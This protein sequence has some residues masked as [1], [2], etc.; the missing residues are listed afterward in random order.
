MCPAG[1]TTVSAVSV[2]SS[3]RDGP[4]S[5]TITGMGPLSGGAQ[6]PIQ[7]YADAVA[8]L[9]DPDPSRRVAALHSLSHLGD[10][11]PALRP[12]IVDVICALV[13]SPDTDDDIRQLA[14]RLL[15]QHLHPGR[16][17]HWPGMTVDLSYATLT[18]LDLSQCRIGGDLRLDRCLLLGQTRL[19]GL[20]VGGSM[21]ARGARFDG[22]VWLERARFGGPVWLD[23]TVFGA[24]AWFGETTFRAW[25]SFAGT[26]FGGHAWFGAA[27]FHAPVDLGHAVFRRSAGFRGVDAHGPVSLTGTTFHGPARVSLR[28]DQWNIIGPGWRVE[29]D[30]DNPAV[31]RLFWVGGRNLIEKPVLADEPTPV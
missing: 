25:A 26:D 24:D 27:T 28:G 11:S 1:S 9:A 8:G 6:G 29:V 5:F 13:R 17:A 21:V 7:Q 23:G 18:D 15:Q 19:R 14:V 16:G 12:A 30:D 2:T 4:A 22:D 20:N 3:L 31:G 10:A